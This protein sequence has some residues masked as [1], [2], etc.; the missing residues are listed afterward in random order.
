ML[1]NIRGRQATCWS[2]TDLVPLDGRRGVPHP[3]NLQY[4]WQLTSYA[5]LYLAH[6]LRDV[7]SKQTSNHLVY[8]RTNWFAA[9]TI[10]FLAPTWD[11]EFDM[12]LADQT[13]RGGWKASKPCR[14]KSSYKSSFELNKCAVDRSLSLDINIVHM[15]TSS[16]GLWLSTFG[17]HLGDSMVD[18]VCF[19]NFRNTIRHPERMEDTLADHI[20][21]EN[22]SHET[23]ASPWC[24]KLAML[25][26]NERC[27]GVEPFTD[28]NLKL[29]AGSLHTQNFFLDP[30][31]CAAV[32]WQCCMK[33]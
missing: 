18:L 31:D 12:L 10:T 1:Q 4:Y 29:G 24:S 30:T 19:E 33:C 3:I 6:L 11:D 32:K 8:L 27:N 21:I 16:Y 22:E 26:C 25:L 5:S 15:S 2:S 13:W 7:W 14:E 17:L 9:V 20:R 28:T 23:R